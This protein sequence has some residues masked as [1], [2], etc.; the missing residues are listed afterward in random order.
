MNQT[1]RRLAIG[2]LGTNQRQV[3]V[4]GG[5]VNSSPSRTLQ[6]AKPDLDGFL[7]A[8]AKA[9]ADGAKT[10]RIAPGSVQAVSLTNFVRAHLPADVTVEALTELPNIPVSET[11][12]VEASTAC[13]LVPREG[14]DLAFLLLHFLDWRGGWLI[15][16]E[17]AR[18]SSRSPLFLVAMPKAGANL[19]VEFARRLG[20]RDGVEF[21]ESAEP[22]HWYYL[23]HS[24][25]H[26]AA[27][28]FFNGSLRRN[29]SDPRAHAFAR[30]PTLFIYRNPLEIWAAE[31]DD[32]QKGGS[33]LALGYLRDL[34]QAKRLECLL[35]DPWLLGSVRDRV[36]RFLAWLDF[37]SVIPLSYEELIGAKGGGD[38]RAQE[39]LVW[40]IQLKLR[41]PG[42]PC[43]IVAGMVEAGAPTL[44][45]GN[46]GRYRKVL[47]NQLF[48]QFL[49][50]KQDF[51]DVLGYTA[52]DWAH[53]P[54]MSERAAEFRRQPLRL[55]DMNDIVPPLQLRRKD[56]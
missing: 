50:T 35:D 47:T 56:Q 29:P 48:Q 36:G 26:T 23:E 43:R 17:T 20:Y 45:D 30:T 52:Q 4:Y 25:P 34:S 13:V 32:V 1:H 3:N 6:F 16:P 10:V 2:L 27:T 14:Q 15:A 11:A 5:Q 40:S 38:D 19:L 42:Q 51:M 22:A 28:D 8:I 49:R 9:V 24:N 39:D 44:D 46:A 31:G 21:K 37:P 7:R 33:A 53:D 55:L 12:G 54:L 41:V 18:S